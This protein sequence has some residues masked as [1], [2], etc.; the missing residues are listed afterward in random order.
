MTGTLGASIVRNPQLNPEPKSSPPTR[1]HFSLSLHDWFF[2]PLLQDPETVE[3]LEAASPDETGNGTCI[4]SANS[5]VYSPCGHVLPFPKGDKHTTVHGTVM[6]E[7]ALTHGIAVGAATQPCAAD[8]Y[9]DRNK[10]KDSEKYE[11]LTCCLCQRIPLH[12]VIT[13]KCGHFYCDICF[14]LDYHRQRSNSRFERRPDVSR[15]KCAMC[16]EVTQGH[17]LIWPRTPKDLI[18]NDG[19][20]LKDEVLKSIIY[21]S[22]TVRVSLGDDL[23]ESDRDTFNLGATARHMSQRGKLRTEDTQL[24]QDAHDAWIVNPDGTR[25]RLMDAELTE[26]NTLK[27]PSIIK[28]KKNRRCWLHLAHTPNST[29]SIGGLLISAGRMAATVLQVRGNVI[30]LELLEKEAVAEKP[31]IEKF[32][33][34]CTLG[35]AGR[36]PEVRDFL[37]SISTTKTTGTI[38]VGDAVFA[39][40]DHQ[41]LNDWSQHITDECERAVGTCSEKSAKYQNAVLEMNMFKLRT[42]TGETCSVKKLEYPTL[43]IELGHAIWVHD[44]LNACIMKLV[45]YTMD[46]NLSIGCG[47]RV[48]I[49]HLCCILCG[50]VLRRARVYEAFQPTIW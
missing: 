30:T 22:I 27:I 50:F 48:L 5:S 15:M 18:T 13:G 35:E 2:R 21:N 4:S 46:R 17:P 40:K 9:A 41:E 38:H 20:P 12:P 1:T 25:S 34:T 7:A 31:A 29:I 49:V 45:S 44:S 37:P 24:P 33:R 42:A 36:L 3:A 19:P 28:D 6:F 11:N 32:W 43:E 16:R 39:V 14:Q 10:L 23:Q 26:E 8:G 47:G